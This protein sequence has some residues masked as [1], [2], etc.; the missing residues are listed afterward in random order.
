MLAGH[1]ASFLP[2][3]GPNILAAWRPQTDLDVD[4]MIAG[5]LL[6]ENQIL[7]DT[8]WTNLSSFFGHGGKLIFYHGTADPVFSAFDT[9]DYYTKMAD[10]N[11]GLDSGDERR[12]ASFSSRA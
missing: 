3:A 9:L 4:K 5:T 10:A 8:T 6:N 1:S 2:N 12:A 7:T 11:G